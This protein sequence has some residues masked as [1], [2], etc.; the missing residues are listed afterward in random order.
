[1]GDCICGLFVV[2]SCATCT[3]STCH[4]GRTLFLGY[5]AVWAAIPGARSFVQQG[6][7]SALCLPN[8]V[9]LSWQFRC[10]AASG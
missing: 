1:M 2:R 4:N 3:I 9:N 10:V 7:H 5:A 6:V 8:V